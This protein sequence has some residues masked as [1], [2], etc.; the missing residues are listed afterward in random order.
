MTP[1][2]AGELLS[3]QANGAKASK[4]AI[5]DGRRRVIY[6]DVLRR[7][8]SLSVSLQERGV[9]RGDRVVI[10]LPRSVEAVVALFGTWFAG[11]V[12]VIANERLRSQQVHHVVE[13]SQASCVVTDDRQLLAVPLFPCE[14]VINIDREAPRPGRPHAFLTG[15]DLAM[16]VYTSGSTGLPKGIMLS[17]D[18]LLAGTRIVAGYLHL[19]EHDVILSVLP[20]SF[21]YGLNQLLTAFFVGATLVIQR[22]M[23]PPDISQTL[24]RERI[25]GMAGVPTFW[26]QLTGRHSPFLKLV[27]PDLRYI[28]NSGGRFPESVVRAIRTAHPRLQIFPMYGLTEAFRSTYLPPDQVDERPSSMGKAIPEVDILVINEQGTECA[29]NEIGELVHCGGTVSMGYWR[30]PENTA[31]MFR[32]HPLRAH[33]NGDAERVVFSGDL[34]KKDADGYLYYVGR[35]DKQIK[36]RGV[37]VSPEEIERCIHTS[38]V[39]SQVVSFAVTREDG[40]TDIV[41]AVVPA[42]VS[43]FREEMLEE[44]CRNAMPEYMQPRTFWTM[45][46]FP[47]T[48][49][50]KPDRCEIERQYVAH[51]RHPA[52]AS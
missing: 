28:T 14:Q 39:V 47:L 49:S 20:F 30:D 45:R 9:R 38:S 5:V 6:A 11:A 48:S 37:R 19:I 29:A 3:L 27:Y 23:F 2:N 8:E 34:V 15:A 36:S 10:F 51:H 46:E 18:N 16:L 35:K 12:A 31:R 7:A 24:L 33:Q 17:H 1:G 4:V 21:D 26:V 42:D 25:T 43:G 40:D 32:P 41:A 44:F 22:S 52:T 13:H 50:G